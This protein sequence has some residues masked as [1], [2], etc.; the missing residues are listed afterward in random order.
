MDM[1]D[2]SGLKDEMFTHS[3][4]CMGVFAFPD[5]V[6]GIREI[7]RM[8]QIGGIAVVTTWKDQGFMNFMHRVQRA[9]RPDLPVWQM[10]SME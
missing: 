10:Q 2:L 6:K 3:I 5:P 4:T 8:L 9:V 7:H 1:S